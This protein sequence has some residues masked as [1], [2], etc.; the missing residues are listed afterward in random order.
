[1]NVKKL[2]SK[3]PQ[4][5]VLNFNPINL[6]DYMIQDFL[7][8]IKNEEPKTFS[9]EQELHEHSIQIFMNFQLNILKKNW[10]II[11]FSLIWICAITLMKM[12]LI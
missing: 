10:I 4:D 7:M 11:Q 1:M 12:F 3:I 8:A 6:K 2:F 9:Y 5:I